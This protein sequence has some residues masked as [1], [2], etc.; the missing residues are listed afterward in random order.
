MSLK[1][2]RES[3]YVAYDPVQKSVIEI[4]G[5]KSL[6]AELP[7]GDIYDG[8]IAAEIF[9]TAIQSDTIQVVKVEDN[10]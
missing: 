2:N 3:F 9:S 10:E 1:E 4:W 7:N 5:D 8:G 6:F